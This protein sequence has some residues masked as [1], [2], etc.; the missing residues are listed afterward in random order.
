M[1]FKK[2]IR[3][4][5]LYSNFIV[6]F[7]RRILVSIIR[8]IESFIL[9]AFFIFG[10]W[11]NW[12]ITNKSRINQRIYSSCYCYTTSLLYTVINDFK[13]FAIV[14][15]ICFKLSLSPTGNKCFYNN[16]QLIYS[17]YLIL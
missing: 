11:A 12:E 14:Y 17:A 13:H 5:I 15:R 10:K 9:V 8:S 3:I 6:C 7:L 16:K 1:D 2:Q 4:Y